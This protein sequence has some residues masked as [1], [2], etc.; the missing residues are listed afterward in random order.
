MGLGLGNQRRASARS[1]LL[2]EIMTAPGDH[3]LEGWPL[4]GG[5]SEWVEEVGLGI[6]QRGE[7]NMVRATLWDWTLIL[8]G[9]E[10]E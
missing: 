1:P 5:T 2:R 6:S 9:W 7:S 8:L 10:M 4:A 3:V